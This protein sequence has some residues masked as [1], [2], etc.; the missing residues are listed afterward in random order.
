MGNV[1]PLS[2]LL[3]GTTEDVRRASVECYNLA[4]MNGFF[5]LGTGC[6]VAPHTPLKNYMEMIR[7]A[8]S[9]HIL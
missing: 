7:T 2:V 6:E 8:R 3:Q 4:G 9:I 5:I 1:D